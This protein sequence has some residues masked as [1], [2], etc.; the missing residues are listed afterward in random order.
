LEYAETARRCPIEKS[1]FLLVHDE[2]VRAVPIEKIV[3][4]LEYSEEQQHIPI[5]RSTFLL[6][7]DEDVRASPM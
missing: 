3:F 4:T 2:D 7:H 1:T 6:V 5:E